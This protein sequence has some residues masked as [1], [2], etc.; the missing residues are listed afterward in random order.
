MSRPPD[1]EARVSAG[2]LGTIIGVYRGRPFEG[3][4]YDRS[5]A[6]LGDVTDTVTDRRTVPLG[7]T[8]DDSSGPVTCL[9]ARHDNDHRRDRT[10]RAIGQTWRND[11]IEQKTIL[12]WGGM[13]SFTRLRP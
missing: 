8:D 5:M 2:L 6:E 3:W 4:T 9:R 10:P 1:D 7:S 13:G 12:W 11:L